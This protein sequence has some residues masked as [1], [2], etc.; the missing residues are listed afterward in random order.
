VAAGRKETQRP[1][2]EDGEE[3]AYELLA[4]HHM[5]R[6]GLEVMLD[7][8]FATGTYAVW[9]E[10]EQLAARV[11]FAAARRVAKEYCALLKSQLK[12]V[13]RHQPGETEDLSRSDDPVSFF[14]DNCSSLSKSSSLPG[15]PS[16]AASDRFP[17]R[18]SP[19]LLGPPPELKRGVSVAHGC[20]GSDP[21]RSGRQTRPHSLTNC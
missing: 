9:I 19:P 11:G 3:Q 18:L 16:S 5:A 20:E 17:I 7:R 6:Q 10:Y 13:S 8:G 21:G 4:S 2:A 1:L 12:Q 14:K 15:E